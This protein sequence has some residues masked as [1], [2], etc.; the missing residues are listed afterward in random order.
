MT[1]VRQVFQTRMWQETCARLKL[2]RLTPKVPSGRYERIKS[3]LSLLFTAA[4]T[5]SLVIAPIAFFTLQV[6]LNLSRGLP[7]L[8]DYAAA[9]AHPHLRMQLGPCHAF[10]LFELLQGQ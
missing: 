10:L 1:L 7:A 2:K 9:H 6:L 3:R 4:Q 5:P 8:K